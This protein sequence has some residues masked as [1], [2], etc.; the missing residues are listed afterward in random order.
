MSRR[1]LEESYGM[2][3]LRPMAEMQLKNPTH[4]SR[5]WS[6]LYEAWGFFN[7][8]ITN[9]DEFLLWCSISPGDRITLDRPDQI[10]DFFTVIGIWRDEEEKESSTWV[11]RL[12]GSNY[13]LLDI[14]VKEKQMF[15]GAMERF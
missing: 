13:S 10:K 9:S 14:K 4:K 12:M 1:E 8:E 6:D 11:F 15:I 5:V 3:A 2:S 7:K